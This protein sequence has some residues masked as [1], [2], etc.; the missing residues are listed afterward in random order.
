MKLYSDWIDENFLAIAITSCASM[1]TNFNSIGMIYNELENQMK[2]IKNAMDLTKLESE[3]ELET[4]QDPENWPTQGEIQIE[5]VKMQYSGTVRLALN[6]ISCHIPS[7]DKVGI[8]GRTGSGKSSLIST[9]Y[10]FYDIK[11]GRI[12]IDDHDIHEI[13][14]HNLRSK[15]SYISQTPFLRIATV[16]ENLDPYNYYTDEEIIESL[17]DV[18]MWGYVKLLKDG[19][20]TQITAGNNLFSVGQKQLICIARA[21][22]EKNTILSK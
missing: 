2:V 11:E 8:K 20:N 1:I 18:Q 19:I 22:L 12:I 6:D 5:N 7:F 16:R 14:L 13:G 4:D 10:R 21:I 15:I 9:I 3:G 17:K